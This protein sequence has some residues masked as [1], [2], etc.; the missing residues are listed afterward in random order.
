MKVSEAVSDTRQV[1]ADLCELD[2]VVVQTLLSLRQ[3]EPARRY[4]V[5]QAVR[6]TVL[7]KK[8][9][10]YNNKQVLIMQS[11]GASSVHFVIKAPKLVQD[12]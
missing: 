1:C 6:L 2:T 10:L 3:H 11:I 7:T 8:K 12:R 5:I 4:L 9:H